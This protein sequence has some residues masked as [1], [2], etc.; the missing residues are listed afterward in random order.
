MN[1]KVRLGLLIAALLLLASPTVLLLIGFSILS[2][3]FPNLNEDIF[4]S[5]ELEREPFQ[6]G[7]PRVPNRKLALPSQFTEP[8]QFYGQSLVEVSEQL[9]ATLAETGDRFTA[10]DETFEFYAQAE[11]GDMISYI[12]LTF[13]EPQWTCELGEPTF[14]SR[15]LIPLAGIYTQRWV[16]TA[17]LLS[18]DIYRDNGLTMEVYCPHDGGQYMI[19]LGFNHEEDLFQY[20]IDLMERCTECG[21]SDW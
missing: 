12:E 9:D 14:S 3:V 19:S 18:F 5:L 15:R 21:Q 6:P 4:V 13:R 11:D 20:G 16:K 8:H 2:I 17:E 1:P 10:E 7:A